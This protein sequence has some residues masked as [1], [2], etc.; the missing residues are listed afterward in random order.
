MM[1]ETMHRVTI[2]D[3][4][5]LKTK[6][7][8]LIYTLPHDH[9]IS[10]IS[11]KDND[12]CNHKT[13]KQTSDSSS[14]PQSSKKAGG[15]ELPF[16]VGNGTSTDRTTSNALSNPTNFGLR[17]LSLELNQRIGVVVLRRVSI[18]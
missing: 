6:A 11:Q 13:E 16:L 9:F 18:R 8:S 7:L 12:I 17:C 14:R 10:F 15:T 4:L 1:Q 2:C 3:F 5:F